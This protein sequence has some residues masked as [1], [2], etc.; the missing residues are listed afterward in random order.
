MFSVVN[1]TKIEGTLFALSAKYTRD[2]VDLN[3]AITNVDT[4]SKLEGKFKNERRIQ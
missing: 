1:H 4:K 3:R 2:I